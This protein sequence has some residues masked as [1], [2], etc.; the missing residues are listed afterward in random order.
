MT[1]PHSSL[2]CSSLQGKKL[3]EVWDQETEYGGIQETWISKSVFGGHLFISIFTRS[4]GL[5][6]PLNHIPLHPDPR[7]C[8]WYIYVDLIYG[9]LITI[10]VIHAF[11]GWKFLKQQ[12]FYLYH[13]QT[14]WHKSTIKNYSTFCIL[15]LFSSFKLSSESNV[16]SQARLINGY[17]IVVLHHQ[18]SLQRGFLVSVKV[19]ISPLGYITAINRIF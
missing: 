17:P 14:S 18:F 10:V 8:S 2:F 16:I 1:W 9:T 12:R 5:V 11:F 3:F 4:T 19:E 13:S 15:S 7:N 6:W